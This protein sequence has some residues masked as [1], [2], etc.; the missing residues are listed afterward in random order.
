METSRGNALN[1]SVQVSDVSKIYRLSYTLS[2][3][4]LLQALTSKQD[5]SKIER[6]K[7]A[8]DRVSFSIQTGDR[9]GIV[10]SNGAGK[11]TL[12][13]MITGV[14]KPTSGNIEVVGHVTAVLTLGVGLREDLSGRENIYIDGEV[15]GK[16]RSEI[17]LIID[18]IIEFAELGEF[19]DYPVRTYSTGMKSRLAFSMLV[20]IEP[21]ILI[22]DEALSAGDSVFASKASQ[23]IREICNKGKIVILVSHSMATIV[24]MCDRCIWIDQGK[25]VMDGDPQEVTSAYLEDVRKANEALLIEK[26]SSY[27]K[28]VSWLQGCEVISV[29]AYYAYESKPRNILIAKQDVIIRICLQ[30]DI[31]LDNPDIR[32]QIKRL[33]GMVFSD[34]LLSETDPTFINT[35][36]SR[37]H[38][39]NLL[40]GLYGRIAYDI[41]MTPLVLGKG[42][43]VLTCELL[44]QDM[45][46]ASKSTII[47]VVTP[48]NSPTG[49]Q[50]ALFYPSTIALACNEIFI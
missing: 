28:S 50:P 47:E 20:C 23:K 6:Y 29:E 42:K 21:E 49:V 24:E 16:S 5:S 31:L 8:V 15:Q 37:A 9:L 2:P 3:L 39:N 30:V 34:Q 38:S 7:V 10:G 44:N 17:N 43:Y 40:K 13:Q 25:I 46:F 22:I 41:C 12:L 1:L 4:S 18:E 32:F 19:I 35:N 26:Y 33:D 11:S 45:T 48:P 14:S 27:M 36:S